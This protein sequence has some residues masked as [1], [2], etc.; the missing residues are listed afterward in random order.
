MCGV[1]HSRLH[2]E[3][4]GL[5]RPDGDGLLRLPALAVLQPL[6]RVQESR[7]YDTLVDRVYSD[8]YLSGMHIDLCCSIVSEIQGFGIIARM[9]CTCGC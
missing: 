8:S 5:V 1:R 9:D 6:Q 2:A 4:A 7:V 3:G